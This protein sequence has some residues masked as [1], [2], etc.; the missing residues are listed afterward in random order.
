M[1]DLG[2]DPESQAGAGLALGGDK[3]LEDAVQHCFGNAHAAV[4]DGDADA[5]NGIVCRISAVANANGQ[6]A[7]MAHGVD[8]IDDEV[9]KDLPQL[10]GSSQD[11][12]G[13]L[14]LTLHVHPGRRDLRM[15]ESENRFEH[16][17]H[18]YRARTG[19]LAIEVQGVFRDLGDA[20]ELLFGLR[21][22]VSA[23][24][25]IG[26]S[27]QEEE[28]GDRLQGIID[29]VRDARGEASGDGQLFRFAQRV[30][31]LF[32]LL[33]L[34][35]HLVLP[36]AG[37]Q[38]I[39]DGADQG[40]RSNRPLQKEDIAER[41]A[42]GAPALWQNYKLVNVQWQPFDISQIDTTGTNT[43][44][45]VSTF[46]LA[47]SVVE[48]D[49]TLQ[50]F[51][52]GLFAGGPPASQFFKSAYESFT[53][54]NGTA[55]NIY[56][57]PPANSVPPASTQFSRTNMGGCMGCHGRAERAG[58]DFSFTLK[59]GPVATPEFGVASNAP[60]ATTATAT[61]TAAASAHFR[62]G[63]DQARLQSLRE[64]LGGH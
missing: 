30:L 10:A 59:E 38:S 54:A 43:S 28:V 46:S 6:A 33:Q 32:E 60:T 8:R 15:I 21:Q 19:G 12:V 53:I 11:G 40:F 49:N 61:T 56:G 45:L 20:R 7:A 50:Q 3:R 34:I 35:A 2:S 52:G 39:F 17:S 64:A 14:K 36:V 29:L 25:R 16:G 22:I 41:L 23:T 5:A 9:G 42:Y 26:V 47:N 55:Y 31:R 27:H 51:F 13:R 62:A 58:A 18:V 37:A 1:D 4:R 57:P 44:R 24:G 48:T 63:L